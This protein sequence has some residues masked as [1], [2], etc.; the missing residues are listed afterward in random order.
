MI[1]FKEI[2]L[3]DKPAIARRL[4]AAGI[5]SCDYTFVNIYSWRHAYGTVWA[6]TG[7]VMAVRFELG[8]EGYRG[9]MLSEQGDYCRIVPE[10]MADARAE[11]I[12]F[13]MVGMS[14]SGAEAF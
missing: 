11:G 9:Y 12:R 8:A 1:R 3:T 14:R 6:E 13:R 2:L 10:L 4:A 7:G 5:P